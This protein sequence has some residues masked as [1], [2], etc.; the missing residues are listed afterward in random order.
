MNLKKCDKCGSIGE[1]KD[2]NSIIASLSIDQKGADKRADLCHS[3]TAEAKEAYEI[4]LANAFT[5]TAEK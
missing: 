1:P 4:F 5:V 3:C 2:F